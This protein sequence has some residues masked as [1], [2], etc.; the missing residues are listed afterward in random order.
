MSHRGLF[1]GIVEEIFLQLMEMH[2]EEAS[3]M[4]LHHYDDRLPEGSLEAIER[5]KG[6][7]KLSLEKLEKV[8]PEKLD[9]DHRMDYFA[10][11]DFLRLRLFY[12]EDWPRWKMYP[13]AMDTLIYALIPIFMKEYAPLQE[14]FENIVARIERI[15]KFLD[16]SRSRLETPIRVFLNLGVESAERLKKLIES[17]YEYMH[18]QLGKPVE[19][20]KD[21]FDRAMEAIEKYKEWINTQRPREIRIFHMGEDNLR[22]YFDIRGI[23]LQPSELLERLNLELKA[24]REDLKHVVNEINGKMTPIDVIEDMNNKRPANFQ[25]ALAAYEK[26]I[27]EAKRVTIEKGVASIPDEYLEVKDTPIV[28]RGVVEPILYVPPGKYE[29]NKVGKLLITPIEAEE[30]LRLHNAYSI[31]HLAVREGYPGKHL[32][33]AWNV[34]NRSFVRQLVDAPESLEGWGYYVDHTMSELGYLNSPRDRFYRLLSLSR[35]ICLAISDIKMSLGDINIQYIVKYLKKEAYMEEDHALSEALL[36][37]HSP[38]FQLSKYYGYMRF[39]NLRETIRSILGPNFTLKWYHD[40]ILQ[41][42][43]LPLRY[44]ELL[45]LYKAID[46]LI[47]VKTKKLG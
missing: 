22:K 27:Q 11:R 30:E 7:L 23:D 42:G 34:K 46:H 2:P 43:I 5:E 15:P 25:V 18:K 41:S 28:I 20:K 3:Y 9:I 4:G 37:A 10:L 32:M 16:D 24:V 13:E 31:A 1:E 17:I 44:L 19:A 45:T 35:I 21:V 39:L 40:T 6:F 26:A 8:N 12:I 47:N 38:G 29:A 36:C 33:N 14:R